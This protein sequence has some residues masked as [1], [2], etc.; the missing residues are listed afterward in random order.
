MSIINQTYYPIPL[1]TYKDKYLLYEIED[2]YYSYDINDENLSINYI[3]NIPIKYLSNHIKIKCYYLKSEI[4]IFYS[5]YDD[6]L[7]KYLKN[8]EIKNLKQTNIS[9][10]SSDIKYFPKYIIDNIN[11]KNIT[12]TYKCVLLTL[13]NCKKINIKKRLSTYNYISNIYINLGNILLKLSKKDKLLEA[14]YVTFTSL[15]EII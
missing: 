5:I 10:I 6:Y 2:L 12:D 3:L 13:I 1:L 7:S 11:D 4:K 8:D 15:Y 9:Y 14:D